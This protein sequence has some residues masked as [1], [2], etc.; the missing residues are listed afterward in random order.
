M[1]LYRMP[2]RHPER[3]QEKLWIVRARDVR[4]SGRW[5]AKSRCSFSQFKREFL[6]RRAGVE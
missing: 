2:R 6:G 4:Q 3:G 1:Q 5:T